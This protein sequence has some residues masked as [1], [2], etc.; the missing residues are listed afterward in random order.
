MGR[1]QGFC[2]MCIMEAHVNK[3]LHSSTSAIQPWAVISVLTR[4]GEHFQL[5]MQQDA[6]EFLR[7]TVDAM[8]RACLSGSS[9]LDISSQSTT[10]VNQIFAGV[11]RSRVTCL[12]CKGVSD[13]YEAFLDVP[14][15]I[16][17]RG[18]VIVLQDVPRAL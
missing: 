17:V 3:V 8:Q 15:D 16:K 6:H 11:L 14:L 1:Q 10:I 18:F 4:I 9:N 13:S 5:G 7:Y 12:S 2:M